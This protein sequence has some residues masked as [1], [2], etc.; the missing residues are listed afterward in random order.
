MCSAAFKSLFF[1]LVSLFSHTLQ[2]HFLVSLPKFLFFQEYFLQIPKQSFKPSLPL[3]E[4]LPLSLLI[5]LSLVCERFHKNITKSSFPLSSS[6]REKSSHAGGFSL[7]VFF[8]FFV[9]FYKNKKFASF[10]KTFCRKKSIT[11]VVQ[12]SSLKKSIFILCLFPFFCFSLSLCYKR[13]TQSS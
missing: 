6:F 11:L 3:K 13:K 5:S 9:A 10:E 1:F 8:F 4:H 12:A 7:A 2:I